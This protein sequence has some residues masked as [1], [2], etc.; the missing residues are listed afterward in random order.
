MLNVNEKTQRTYRSKQI[1][2]NFVKVVLNCYINIRFAKL[3]VLFVYK[4]FI[5]VLLRFITSFVV[6]CYREVTLVTCF[7]CYHLVKS[8]SLIDI[9]FT[10]ISINAGP[11]CVVCHSHYSC[12]TRSEHSVPKKLLCFFVNF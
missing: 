7:I 3:D 4:P 5:A 11:V 12:H 9:L 8:P 1:V 2:S 10:D 6:N